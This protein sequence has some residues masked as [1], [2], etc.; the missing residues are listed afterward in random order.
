MNEYF[1]KFI[2]KLKNFKTK[3]VAYT[4]RKSIKKR[5]IYVVLN[6][7]EKAY[8]FDLHRTNI[9]ISILELHQK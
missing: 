6:L 5:L 1:L 7:K 4:L 3:F 8:L 2:K 9:T